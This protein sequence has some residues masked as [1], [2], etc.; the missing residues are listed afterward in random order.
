MTELFTNR[1]DGNWENLIVSP[2]TSTLSLVKRGAVWTADLRSLVKDISR[3]E[4]DSISEGTYDWQSGW[5]IFTEKPDSFTYECYIGKVQQTMQVTV[6]LTEPEATYKATING[7]EYAYAAGEQVSLAADAFYLDGNWGYRFEAW[8]GDVDAV[9]DVKSS[10]TT[11]TMPAQ[12]LTITAN[13]YLI[14]D[15]DGNGVVDAVDAA[16]IIRMAN[17]TMMPTLAGDITGTGV[18]D[19]MSAANIA[20]Y[21]A[22]TFT[23]AK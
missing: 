1:R 9:A 7:T 21:I 10:T 12:D 13:H 8:T 4:T 5:I 18:V 3:I 11:F 15:V 14:G 17:G 16:A 19:A 2:Q 23:P 20:R 22:G 6:H